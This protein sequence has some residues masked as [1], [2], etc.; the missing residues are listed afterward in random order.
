MTMDQRGIDNPPAAQWLT[1]SEAAQLLG[2]K[3]ATVYSY[4][5]KGILRSGGPGKRAGYL[6]AEVTRLKLRAEARLGHTAVAAGALRWGEP[7]LDSA[8]TSINPRLGPVYR[9][10]PASELAAQQR[11]ETVAELLWSG[12]LQAPGRWQPPARPPRLTVPRG[13]PPLIMLTHVAAQLAAAPGT[14]YGLT[15]EFELERARAA[16]RTFAAALSFLVEPGRFARAFAQPSIAEV[17]FLALSGRAPG[18]AELRALELT[19]ILFADHEL[20]AS[21]FSARV[22]ASAGADLQACL[23][24]AMA[25]L[26][27]PRHG[28]AC[29]RVEALLAE[30]ERDGARPALERRL[31]QGELPPGFETG[32]YPEGDPR[33]APLLA[34]AEK[35]GRGVSRSVR[36]TIAVMRELTGALP[37]CD[38]A[39]VALTS[40]LKL[41]A[42][43]ASALFAV[44]RCAGW[45]A[46]VLEQRESGTAIRPRARYVGA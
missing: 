9:A 45:V 4:A 23:V 43:S 12:L 10:H 39:Q 32:A 24:A 15:R 28:G 27:G 8:I 41:P 11:F 19:L 7:V 2:V 35:V 1:A 5:A 40:A 13:V 20:N 16:I 21:T 34:A 31:A 44:G 18:K 22:A 26:S 38:L 33:T 25:T 30:V 6:R 36:Q 17:A 46:H 42:G 29:D 3:K 14:R 37:A